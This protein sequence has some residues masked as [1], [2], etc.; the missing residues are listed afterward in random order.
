MLGGSRIDRVN[1]LVREEL[2]QLML[3]EID[4]PRDT[5]VTITRVACSPD[6]EHARVWISILPSDH[7][8]N[9]MQLLTV[10]IGELQH[11]L[12]ATLKMLPVPRIRFLIDDTEDRAARI[13]GILDSLDG[14]E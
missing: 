5:L 8:D 12:N 6:L 10:K 2:S 7:A 14:S 9:V 11:G 3:R 13:E 1:E 4:L